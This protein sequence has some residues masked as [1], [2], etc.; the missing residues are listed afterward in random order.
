M[1]ALNSPVVAGMLVGALLMAVMS[2]ADSAL[3]S[4][5]AIFVKDLFEHELG[6]ELDDARTLRRARICSAALGGVAILVAAAWRDVIALLL[7][8]YQLWAPA[9]IVPVCV[10]IFSKRHDPRLA[11]DVL[12]T[13]LVAIAATL[14][15]RWSAFS[16]SFDPSVFG[17][18]VAL[19]TFG[20]LSVLSFGVGERGRWEG[21]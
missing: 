2:S 7:F 11:R 15:Y 17:V 9:V 16:V 6:W 14:L 19:T 10:G 21:R 3:N 18:A 12:V 5:T 13:M 8:T 20:G 1:T 4:A